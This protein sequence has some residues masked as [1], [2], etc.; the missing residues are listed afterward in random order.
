MTPPEPPTLD[1]KLVTFVLAFNNALLLLDTLKPTS[2]VKRAMAACVVMSDEIR[3]RVQTATGD[4]KRVLIGTSQIKIQ[5]VKDVIMRAG[6]PLAMVKARKE[7]IE[8]VRLLL[9]ETKGV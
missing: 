2:S 6:M 5:G 1:Q 9:E 8:A 3:K 7:W 4:D